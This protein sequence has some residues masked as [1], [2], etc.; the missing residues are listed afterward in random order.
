MPE[1]VLR[2]LCVLFHLF[3][4]NYT[5]YIILQIKKLMHK[6]QKASVLMT[7]S[8][9]LSRG[10]NDVLKTRLSSPSDVLCT[11][12]N[13]WTDSPGK[14]A[15]SSSRPASLSMQKLLLLIVPSKSQKPEHG[16]KASQDHSWTRT[17][18]AWRMEYTNWT[19][20]GHMTP[21]RANKESDT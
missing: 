3:Q 12:C 20:T 21:P 9:T 15:T 13:S 10:S 14:K 19:N 6:R 8:I 1:T 18:V 16:L 2:A 17:P 4:G 7:C 11:D 5:N